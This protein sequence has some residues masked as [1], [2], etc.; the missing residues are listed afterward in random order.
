M[1]AF[2]IVVIS[3]IFP[4]KNA[5]FVTLTARPARIYPLN[6]HLVRKMHRSLTDHAL[7]TKDSLLILPIQF[8]HVQH[9][10]PPAENAPPQ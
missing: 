10:P 6:A 1:N 4:R 8:S 3:W 9:A 7:A 5:N 2:V